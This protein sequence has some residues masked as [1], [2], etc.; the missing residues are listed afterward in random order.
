MKTWAKPAAALQGLVGKIRLAF[1][2]MLLPAAAMTA[3]SLGEIQAF[4]VA[5]SRL[6]ERELPALAT[7]DELGRLQAEFRALQLEHLGEPGPSEIR[8]IEQRLENQRAAIARLFATYRQSFGAD[9]GEEAL[10]T[11]AYAAL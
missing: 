7:I 11:E 9:A 2:A 4:H 3:I 10:L 1:L 6:D 5:A 8:S